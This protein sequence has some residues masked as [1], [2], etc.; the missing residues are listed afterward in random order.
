MYDK[1]SS[2]NTQIKKYK[3]IDHNQT[4]IGRK[5][6]M[7]RTQDKLPKWVVRRKWALQSMSENS[8]LRS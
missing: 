5:S 3:N 7:G 4:E 1:L 2:K 6:R 8:A